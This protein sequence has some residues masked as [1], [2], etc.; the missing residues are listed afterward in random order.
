[1]ETATNLHE[2]DKKDGIT[3]I[4]LGLTAGLEEIQSS[5]TG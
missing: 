5:N 2:V 3:F 4:S 1:M